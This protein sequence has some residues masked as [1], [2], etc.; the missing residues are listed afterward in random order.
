MSH[1]RLHAARTMVREG[2]VRVYHGLKGEA[3]TRCSQK[4]TSVETWV[5]QYAEEHGE[6]QPHKQETH[7]PLGLSKEEVW[8]EYCEVHQKS[9]S[10]VSLP[11]WYK[12]LA[13]KFDSWLKFPS[14][15]TFSECKTCSDLKRARESASKATKGIFKKTKSFFASHFS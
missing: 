6:P 9:P 2:R 11:Y 8:D 12:I 7:M 3:S 14:I 5:R 10:E 15:S 13:E 4:K 1:G